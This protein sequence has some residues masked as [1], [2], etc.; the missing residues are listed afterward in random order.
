MIVVIRGRQANSLLGRFEGALHRIFERIESEN[1][2]VGVNPRKLCPGFVE[3]R[4]NLDCSF[5]TFPG[6]KVVFL[7]EVLV[8]GQ[9]H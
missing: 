9:C 1:V 2:L 8:I 7:A 6:F 3:L 4:V 5:Q